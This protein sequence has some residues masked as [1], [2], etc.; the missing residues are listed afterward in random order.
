MTRTIV[1]I[2]LLTA[3]S[4]TLLIPQPTTI[5]SIKEF[6]AKGDGV[7]DDLAAIQKAILSIRQT[8]GTI[9]FPR[10]KSPYRISGTVVIEG[11]HDIVLTGE[12]SILKLSSDKGDLFSGILI[13]KCRRISVT[14]IQI[15]GQKVFRIGANAA[16][17]KVSLSDSVSLMNVT[18][19]D[20]VTNGIEGILSSYCSVERCTVSQTQ[21][22]NGIGWTGGHHNSFLSNTCTVNRGQGIEIRSQQNSIVRGNYCA[23]NGAV[24]EQSS[25]ITVEAEDGTVEITSVTGDSPMKIVTN[26]PHGYKRGDHVR[27]VDRAGNVQTLSNTECDTASFSVERSV[28]SFV[29][30]K[31]MM[32]LF[33]GSDAEVAFA[34][35]NIIVDGNICEKNR[36]FGIYLVSAKMAFVSD[37]TLIN[38]QITDNSHAGIMIT[39][40][41][42]LKEL[43]TTR[44][45]RIQSNSILRNGTVTHQPQIWLDTATD[46]VITGNVID[47][48]TGNDLSIK[49]TDP[50]NIIIEKND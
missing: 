2:L 44:G 9:Q 1:S 43:R 33:N 17:I 4:V 12:G 7:T 48:K 20:A 22:Y 3:I 42:G 32:V 31:G 10:S 5:V 37:V 15:A 35:K 16:G 29:P 25:G 21:N 23:Q 40:A 19:T 36:G 18:V 49:N 28:G 6:G 46:V 26:A 13:R 39:S 24:G 27:F 11:M 38:N 41:A 50:L 34:G 8:G 45:I 14:G 47:R 30:E